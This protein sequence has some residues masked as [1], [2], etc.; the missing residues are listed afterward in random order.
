MGGPARVLGRSSGVLGLAWGVLGGAWGVLGGAW[1]VLGGPWEVLER[2]SRRLWGSLEVLGGTPPN[3]FRGVL[4]ADGRH[5]MQR[6]VDGM[7]VSDPSR[8]TGGVPR[9]PEM[10][11]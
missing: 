6:A 5:G 2:T 4:G 1:S 8:V 11:H 7:R 3:S 9:C 10:S